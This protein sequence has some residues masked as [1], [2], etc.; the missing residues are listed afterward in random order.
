M[1]TY[2]VNLK[3]TSER[4]GLISSPVL[5][6][7]IEVATPPEFPKG[8]EGIWGP[9]QLLLASLSGCLMT[10]FFE[11]A[12]NSKL[13]YISFECKANS[14]VEKV[15]GKYEIT[16]I[17]LKPRLTIPNTQ[18]LDRAKRILEMSKKTCLVSNILKLEIQLESEIIQVKI[19]SNE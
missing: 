12:E 15:D 17:T 5:P 8:A 2:E 19:I 14:I 6:K 16:K 1:H 13:E 3:W 11:I 7:V 4:K 9:E 18:N 10:T